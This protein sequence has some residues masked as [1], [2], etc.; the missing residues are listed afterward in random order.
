[1]PSYI[2]NRIIM[3]F[4]HRVYIH[5]V[6]CYVFLLHSKQEKEA[7]FHK[8]HGAILLVKIYAPVMF[9]QLCTDVESILVFGNSSH[10]GRYINK[11]RLVELYDEYVYKPETT[12]EMI[13]STI[14]HEAQ[15]ARLFRLGIGYEEAIRY[16]VER[17][18]FLAERLFG[19]RIPNGEQVIN[20]ANNQ[21]NNNYDG[22]FSNEAKSE[23]NFKVLEELGC[24]MWIQKLLKWYIKRKH[25]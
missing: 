7:I 6:P 13:A 9:S 18:C 8:L 14:V 17:L 11:L 25:T 24:P 16:R 21:L 4:S 10:L 5:G 15:H 3:R 2:V 1:M 22:R 19:L 23:A 12:I 20:H